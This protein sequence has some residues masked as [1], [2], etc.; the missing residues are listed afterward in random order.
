MAVLLG[1][2]FVVYGVGMSVW[3]T[4]RGDIDPSDYAIYG[5]LTLVGAALLIKT[6]RDRR[7]NRR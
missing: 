4:A 1:I 2:G 6:V 3:G 5:F 7:R